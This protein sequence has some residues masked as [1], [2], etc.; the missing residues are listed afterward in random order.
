MTYRAPALTEHG[1]VTYK[2][3]GATSMVSW[4]GIHIVAGTRAATVGEIES[5][6][7]SEETV[8]SFLETDGESG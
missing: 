4:D 1:T 6:E 2:T 7:L 3:I 5:G 8:G